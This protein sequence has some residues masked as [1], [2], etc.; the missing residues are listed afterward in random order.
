MRTEKTTREDVENFIG[1]L[2]IEAVACEDIGSIFSAS[3]MRNEAERLQKL[4][5]KGII[6]QKQTNNS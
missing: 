3:S 6:P 2:E 4:L 1:L 5:D